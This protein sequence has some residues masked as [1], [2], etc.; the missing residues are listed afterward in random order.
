M[1]L[2]NRGPHAG[3]LPQAMGRTAPGRLSSWDPWRCTRTPAAALPLACCPPHLP[4]RAGQNGPQDS[5]PPR[6]ENAPA[7][8]SDERTDLHTRTVD[9]TVVSSGS[10][11]LLV[12]LRKRPR[13]TAQ[14]DFS[15][16]HC[17]SFCS[18]QGKGRS[19]GW[20]GQQPWSHLTKGQNF[21]GS[22][23]RGAAALSPMVFSSSP[24]LSQTLSCPCKGPP[25][26]TPTLNGCEQEGEL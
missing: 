3:P 1:R 5:N 2:D 6:S 12:Y 21:S 8:L 26:P 13:C 22:G 10:G 7:F 16:D 20:S 25:E 17:D 19:P 23:G 9:S 11:V 15:G 4:T 14:A 18:P 24:F